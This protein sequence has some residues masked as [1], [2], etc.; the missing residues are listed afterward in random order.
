M[1]LEIP[2]KVIAIIWCYIILHTY[3]KCYYVVYLW[4]FI[5][6]DTLE[7]NS[8]SVT[9]CNTYFILLLY[10]IFYCFIGIPLWQQCNT[11]ISENCTSVLWMIYL[12]I[13]VFTYSTYNTYQSTL[14]ITTICL[15]HNLLYQRFS[16][17]LLIATLQSQWDVGNLRTNV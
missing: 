11:V 8:N 14:H 10:V 2:Y 16:Y 3:C 15:P 1:Y 4:L 13:L 7:L 6:N 9:L 12:H 5:I 17:T